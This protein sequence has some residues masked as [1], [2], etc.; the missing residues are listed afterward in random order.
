M[1]SKNALLRR[2]SQR[3]GSATCDGPNENDSW[4]VANL[5]LKFP[6]RFTRDELVFSVHGRSTVQ[7][8][9]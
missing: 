7:V 1:L 2:V 8:A 4:H 6:A 9:S 3:V 5:S